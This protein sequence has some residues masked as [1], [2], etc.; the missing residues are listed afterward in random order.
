MSVG[1]LA[2]QGGSGARGGP[3]SALCAVFVYA[4]DPVSQHGIAALLRACAGLVV[5]DD[6]DHC[7]VA[8]L[9]ADEVDTE[10]ARIIVALQ[11][12]GVPRVVLVVARLDDTGLLTAVEAG[13]AGIVHREDA[14]PAHLVDAVLDADAGQV[15][16]PP[17]VAARLVAHVGLL[18]RQALVAPAAA[19]APRGLSQR[20]IEVLRLLADGLHTSE[21]ADRMCYSERTVKG[22][23]QDVT[24]RY[25]LRNRTHAVVF[26]LRQGLI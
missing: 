21:V 12:D 26:A 15:S 3:E 10:T 4:S 6:V 20:E 25:H 16:L 19:P 7:R 11:R 1:D 18:Q 24:R 17:D 2:I 8:V 22:V 23:L 14:D 13:V 5:V 9:M